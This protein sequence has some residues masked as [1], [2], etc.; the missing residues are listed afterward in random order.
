MEQVVNRV[1]QELTRG[2]I[3]LYLV[4]VYPGGA[5]PKT[6]RHYLEERAYPVLKQEFDFHIQ[7]LADAGF[8]TYELSRWELGETEKIRLVKITKAGIDEVDGRPKTSS[9]VRF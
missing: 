3:L 7:Y 9:G 8:V 2:E 4:K 1:R 6:L 5:T